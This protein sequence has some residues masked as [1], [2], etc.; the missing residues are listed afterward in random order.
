MII[1]FYVPTKALVASERGGFFRGPVPLL[2][3]RRKALLLAVELAVSKI[4]NDLASALLNYNVLVVN[5]IVVN[6]DLCKII[7]DPL[8]LPVR[9]KTRRMF[10]VNVL[11]EDRPTLL[12]KPNVLE[13]Y[14]LHRIG[15]WRTIKPKLFESIQILPLVVCV[16]FT[17]E[18]FTPKPSTDLEIVAAVSRIAETSVWVK[19][20]G[21]IDEGSEGFRYIAHAQAPQGF[22]SP[23]R[24][25]LR[26]IIS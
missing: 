12:G 26:G 11:H 1:L 9:Q 20:S 21:S 13:K 14:L 22:S 7:L 2:L 8:D 15:I 6:V 18:C 23:S 19:T 24:L 16:L 5:V 17:E 3:R 10:S 25:R 4:Y